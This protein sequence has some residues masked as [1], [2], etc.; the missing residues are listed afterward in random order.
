MVARKHYFKVLVSLSLALVAGPLR[1]DD[2]ADLVSS[3]RAFATDSGVRGARAAFLTALAD[4]GVVFAPGPTS[5][6]A[7][8]TAR[9]DSKDRLEWAPAMAEVAASGDLGYTSGPWRYIVKGDAK[10]SASGH[11]LT[12]WKKQADGQWKVLVDHGI[13]HADS[14]FPDKVVRRGAIA[15]VPA[16]TWPVGMAELRVADQA[17][18]GQITAAMVSDDFLLLRDGSFP[19]SQTTGEA[20]PAGAGMR[21][22]TG[23]AISAAGDLA[24][25]WGGGV[26]SPSWL[27]I[28]RR[29]AAGDPPGLGWRLAV[30]LDKAAPP[31]AEETR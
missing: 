14:P 24:V 8:W 30:D 28:W 6:K 5:G 3:E 19:T 22:D 16:P 7:V 21:L 27:R 15:A 17:P 12:V 23:Y 29:P 20:L 13:S 18:A 9:A 4:E 25:S 11:Y 1:A 26:D 10:P 31:P 2:Y